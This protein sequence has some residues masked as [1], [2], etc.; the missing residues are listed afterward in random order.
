MAIYATRAI[1]N[2][3][4]LQVTFDA[5]AERLR[6]RGFAGLRFEQALLDTDHGGAVWPSYER[7]LEFLLGGAP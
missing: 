2:G 7:G 5:M 4:V 1:Y 6:G 3:A